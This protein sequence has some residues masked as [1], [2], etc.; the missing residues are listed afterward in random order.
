LEAA[1][2]AVLLEEIAAMALAAIAINPAAVPIASALL[3]KH[4]YR[5]H[6]AGA[7]YGQAERKSNG[8]D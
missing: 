5:K 2:N 3:D 7:T 6:G 1:H 4:F 8:N